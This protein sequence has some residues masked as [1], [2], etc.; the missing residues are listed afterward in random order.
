MCHFLHNLPRFCP[1]SVAYTAND[2]F[3]YDFS[4]AIFR[5]RVAYTVQQF[6]NF[7]KKFFKVYNHEIVNIQ[8]NLS[9]LNFNFSQG[10]L[11][12]LS[13]WKL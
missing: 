8:C 7:I 1:F 2:E 4:L 11:F 10:D 12:F 6:E 3:R 5:S 9:N 13:F